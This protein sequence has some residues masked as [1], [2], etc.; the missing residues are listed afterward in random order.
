MRPET[1]R[2]CRT[3]GRRRDAALAPGKT[4]LDYRAITAWLVGDA[5]LPENCRARACGETAQLMLP[6]RLMDAAIQ[7]NVSQCKVKH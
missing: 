7:N 6:I 5:R 2:Q 4:F 1:E 3:A